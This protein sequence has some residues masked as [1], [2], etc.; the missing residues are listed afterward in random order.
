MR[1]DLGDITPLTRR[2]KLQLPFCKMADAQ[3]LGN[4]EKNMDIGCY[5][6]SEK[7]VI[8]KSMFV[9]YKSVQLALNIE[10]LSI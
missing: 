1:N 10:S 3:S 8:C 2:Q 6:S 5:F 9:T 7:F 4:I